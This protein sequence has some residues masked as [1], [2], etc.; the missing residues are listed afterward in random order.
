MKSATTKT[1]T[2]T[3]ARPA[4]VR[5]PR[6]GRFDRFT[7]FAFKLFGKQG[8]RL[9]SSRPKL[10]EEIMKSNIRVTPEGLISVV[11]LCTTIT[12]LIEIALLA[13]AFATG[14]L[15]FALGMLAPPLVCLVTWKSQKISQ[16]GSSE[17]LDNEHPIII[18][19]MHDIA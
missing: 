9:A 15:Y 2:T 8:K 1:T 6:L 5:P 17:A 11:L 3:T 7:G 14:I 16:S 4:K 12:A 10:V 19:F 13:V 18:D